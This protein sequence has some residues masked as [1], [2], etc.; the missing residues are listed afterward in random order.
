MF[1]ESLQSI[2]HCLI[3]HHVNKSS[4]Q[5]E[6][7]EDEEHILQDI[8]NATDF[9]KEEW[10]QH[11]AKK[12][13]KFNVSHSKTCNSRYFW[14]I[15]YKFTR[16]LL[17]ITAYIASKQ[18]ENKCGHAAVD[19]YQYVDASKNHVGCAGYFKEKWSWVHQ[20]GDWPSEKRHK[21]NFIWKQVKDKQ[22]RK[23]TK[24]LCLCLIYPYSSSSRASTGRLVE[25]T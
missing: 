16:L 1:T 24:K 14:V 3:L 22:K 18:L 21:Q 20:R 13:W 2:S 23:E 8:I 7:R 15:P 6:V 25:E 19:S 17:L 11:L 10:R 12:G 9:L 4:S 5:A